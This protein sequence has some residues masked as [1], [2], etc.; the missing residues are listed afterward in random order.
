MRVLYIVTSCFADDVYLD[1]PL[2]DRDE[3]KLCQQQHSATE[4]P[5]HYS[6]PPHIAVS[7]FDQEVPCREHHD[8]IQN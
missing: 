1:S 8:N 3:V 2:L 6:Y 5:S 4:T 7:Y